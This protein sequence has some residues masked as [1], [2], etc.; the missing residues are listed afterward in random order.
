MYLLRRLRTHLQKASL[1]HLRDILPK[2][3]GESTTQ[4]FPGGEAHSIGPEDMTFAHLYDMVAILSN[5]LRYIEYLEGRNQRLRQENTALGLR[6]IVYAWRVTTL[7]VS[8]YL[9]V[10]R[11]I[12]SHVESQN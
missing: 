5:A 3:L 6:R 11:R 9:Y 7:I 1:Q 2:D 12:L 8:D 4:S 10:F